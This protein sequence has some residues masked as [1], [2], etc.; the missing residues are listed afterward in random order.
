MKRNTI[1]AVIILICGYAQAQET[2]KKGF[3]LGVLPAVS[4][5]SD[6]GF[7]YGAV[8]N[9]FNYG[10]GTQ[11]PKYD[12]SYYLELS[13]YTKGSTVMR[14]YFDSDK[15]LKGV[16]TFVDLSYITEDMLDFFG[17]NGYQSVYS[18]T[19]ESSNRAFYKM[20]QKQFRLLADFRGNLPIE[21]L[22]WE[23]SYNFV[24]YKNGSINY[25]KKAFM[26][27]TLVGTL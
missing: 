19:K 20:S 16:R 26:K 22:Y 21:H 27:N 10:D 2:A 25:D 6:E 23:A 8:L 12:Q 1:L 13:K 9:L 14:F 18:L 17:Y 11:Y 4:Y 7:Q 5:N 3:N 15:L 24:N